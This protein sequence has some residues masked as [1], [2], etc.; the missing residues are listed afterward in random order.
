[1]NNRN[2]YDPINM[3]GRLLIFDKP[4]KL[5]RL[6]PKDCKISFPEKVPVTY[7]FQMNDPAMLLGSADISRDERGLICNTV[8]KMVVKKENNND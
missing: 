4:D 7:Q 2:D 8:I 6:F 5:D 1:M 3:I